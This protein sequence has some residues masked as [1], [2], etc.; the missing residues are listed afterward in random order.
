M[1]NYKEYIELEAQLAILEEKKKTLR[2]NI[3]ADLTAQGK[4]KDETEYGVFSV[5]HKTNWVYT[6]TVK[7]MEEKVKLEK[8]KEQEKGKAKASQTSYLM[9]K[10][11]DETPTASI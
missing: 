8:I 7:K 10:K 11:Q 9:F 6:A 1:N 3:L 2:E 4:D 5:C